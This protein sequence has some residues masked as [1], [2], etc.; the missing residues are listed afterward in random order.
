MAA[1]KVLAT[2][3]CPLHLHCSPLTLTSADTP[4]HSHRRLHSKAGR[5]ARRVSPGLVLPSI[6]FLSSLRSNVRQ[7]AELIIHTLTTRP[8][9][10][11]LPAQYGGEEHSRRGIRPSSTSP[12]PSLVRSSSALLLPFCHL[13]SSP[14]V[15]SSVSLSLLSAVLPLPGRWLPRLFALPAFVS[16]PCPLLRRLHLLPLPLL[17]RRGGDGAQDRPAHSICEMACMRCAQRGEA[18][19]QPVGAEC[20]DCHASM[21]A[22]HCSVC[23]FFDDEPGRSIFHCAQCGICRRGRRDEFF[24]CQRCNCCYAVAMRDAHKC[25]ENVLSSNCPVRCR[26]LTAPATA[27]PPTPP[28][29]P[30]TGC[31]DL[32]PLRVLRCRSASRTCSSPQTRSTSFAAATH[33]TVSGPTAQTL[34]EAAGLEGHRQPS[35]CWTPALIAVPLAVVPLSGLPREPSARP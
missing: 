22:Y 30:L 23:R 12:S 13:S 18:R 35:L 26:R 3:L 8:A 4:L 21:A 24:H 1:R 29:T 27:K 20:V 14:I 33:C 2:P 11:A 31:T 7:D 9:L 28:R 25:I 10:L 5:A 32:L 19:A 34:S 15:P 6:P 17:P 16:D